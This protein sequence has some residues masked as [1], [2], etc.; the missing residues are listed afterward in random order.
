MKQFNVYFSSRGEFVIIILFYIRT[1][2]M[3]QTDQQSTV[4]IIS[5]WFDIQI[6]KT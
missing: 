4:A 2:A 3:R 6:N 1:E 5:S